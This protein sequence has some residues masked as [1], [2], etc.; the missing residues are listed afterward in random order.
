LGLEQSLKNSAPIDVIA[1]PVLDICSSW[2]V[3]FERVTT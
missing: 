3:R 2:L 1:V